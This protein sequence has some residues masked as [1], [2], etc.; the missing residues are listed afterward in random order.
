MADTGKIALSALVFIALALQ[1]GSCSWNQSLAISVADQAGMPVAGANIVIA[2]QQANGITGGDGLAEGTADE[3]GTFM[4]AI[5]NTV[6]EGMEDTRIDITASAYGWEGET[7]AV[8]AGHSNATMAVRFVAPFTLGKMSVIVLQSNGKPAGGAS[9]YITGSNV[10]RTADASGKALLYLPEGAEATGFASYG[11]EG[12]YFS[13]SGAIA[14]EGGGKELIV[15]FPKMG[16]AAAAPGSTMLTVKFMLQNGTP[17]SGE[18]VV[19]SHGG[20]DVSAYTDAGGAVSIDVGANGTV[21]ASVRKNDY[22]YSFAFNVTADGRLKSETAVLAPL[23]KIDY[24]ESRS[25]GAGCYRLSAKASD[26]RLN[27]PISLR[28]MQVRSDNTTAGEIRTELG[29]DGM[30]AGR[31]CAGDGMSVKA[32]A[33]NAYET[34]E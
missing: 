8:Q 18:K 15:K 6:P 10:K 26:P 16:A 28:M 20:A 9:V 24:F 12:D 29:E 11:N 25:D 23:L 2:Y 33:S 3:N 5:G 27:K 1:L 7:K 14:A 13:T 34:V 21:L 17:L 31:V 32:V 22:D 4:A 30:R 19:F